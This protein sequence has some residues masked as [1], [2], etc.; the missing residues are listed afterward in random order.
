MRAFLLAL[1]W[2]GRGFRPPC[3]PTGPQVA[4]GG[5][6]G[7]HGHPSEEDLFCDV[8]HRQRVGALVVAEGA[9]RYVVDAERLIRREWVTSR[10]V[11]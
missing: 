1:Y 7:A 9:D 3:C 2:W 10:Q 4:H 5:R 8:G 6:A 11:V